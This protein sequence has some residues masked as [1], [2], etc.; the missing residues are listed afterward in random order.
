ME[1][2]YG[3]GEEEDED[4]CLRPREERSPARQ[5]MWREEKKA[6]DLGCDSVRD[7]PVVGEQGKY[8]F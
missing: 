5:T 2:K 7:S 4:G 6:V 1:G 8:S 3:A